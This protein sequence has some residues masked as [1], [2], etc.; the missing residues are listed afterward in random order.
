MRIAICDDQKEDGMRLAQHLSEHDLTLFTDAKALLA[1]I[2]TGSDG[3]DLYL[4]DIYMGELNGIALAKELRAHFEDAAICFV[5]S[6]DAFYREAYDI[7]D[8][9]YLLKPV[10]KGQMD[11]LLAR[12]MRGKEKKRMQS[13]SYKW[14]G[15][16]ESVPYSN[17]LYVAS[18]GHNVSIY[19]KDGEV[20]P[21]KAKLS[22]IETQLDPQVFMR[23]HQSFLMNLYHVDHMDGNELIVGQSRVPISRRYYAEFKKRYLSILFEEVE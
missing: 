21:C 11:K 4:L 20:R 19:C 5:S 9:N 18:N 14:N 12:V 2:Q 6:S 16:P 3:Y 23:C 15:M 8:V 22:D 7:M 17:I 10:Q 13:F 1:A